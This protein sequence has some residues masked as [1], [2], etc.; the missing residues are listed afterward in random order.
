KFT[1]WAKEGEVGRKKLSQITRY[2]TIILGLIQ[3][4]GL[5]FG[6]NRLYSLSLVIDPSFTTYVMISIV[7]TA[8]TAFL[9][10][11]GEQ[12]TEHGIGNGISIIIFAGIIAAL[13]G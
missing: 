3:G 5:A 6:F 13:P 12:I 8:G 4:F 2:G 10:W 1:Q 11:L 9:M 7:L